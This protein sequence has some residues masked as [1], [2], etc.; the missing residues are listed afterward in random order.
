MLRQCV[1]R[2][3]SLILRNSEVTVEVTGTALAWSTLSIHPS[4]ATTVEALLPELCSVG[5]S[6]DITCKVHSGFR[7]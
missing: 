2:S 7:P 6:Q 5:Q 3:E 1:L 4:M